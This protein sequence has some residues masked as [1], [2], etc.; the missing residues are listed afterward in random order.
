M[1]SLPPSQLP[2]KPPVKGTQ[3]GKISAADIEDML[4]K[5]VNFFQATL[6]FMIF[7]IVQ[8]IVVRSILGDPQPPVSLANYA[9]FWLCACVSLLALQLTASTRKF[10]AIV[11]YNIPEAS[12]LKISAHG[13]LLP[14]RLLWVDRSLAPTTQTPS[15]PVSIA[16]ALISF[17]V[18]SMCVTTWAF[19]FFFASYD[20]SL[21]FSLLPIALLALIVSNFVQSNYVRMLI[22][23]DALRLRNAFDQAK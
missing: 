22:E 15:V 19:V 6:A 21:L 7:W 9:L 2:P 10:A 8:T 13:P 11:F 14:D 12:R 1:S 4:V 20:L 17:V 3:D 16:V 5:P 18:N 23:L